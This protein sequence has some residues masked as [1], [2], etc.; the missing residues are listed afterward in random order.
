MS[1]AARNSPTIRCGDWWVTRSGPSPDSVAE[2][3]PMMKVSRPFNNFAAGYRIW[4]LKMTRQQS[5]IYTSWQA[6]WTIAEFMESA[7]RRG[8]HCG[9][10]TKNLPRSHLETLTLT[11][12]LTLHLC[13]NL[14]RC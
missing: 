14:V 5:R 13:I 9:A 8:V 1:L 2:G 11:I 6:G 12:E 4:Q 10:Y 3:L 7:T